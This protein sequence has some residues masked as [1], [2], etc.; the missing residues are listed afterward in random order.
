M[1]L[2]GTFSKVPEVTVLFWILKILTT[3]M[4]EVASDFLV[5]VLSPPTAIC[6]GAIGFIFAL[7]MQLKADRYR[8]WIYWLSIV[9][10]SVLGTMVADSM[11]VGLGIPYAFSTI[12]FII[13]LAALFAAWYSAE[14]TLSIHSI[15]TL[16]RELFYWGI[17]LATFALGTAA[18]DMTAATFHLGYLVSGIVFALLI[19]L[20][21]LARSV[22]KANGIATFWIAYILTRPLGASFAD[23]M[24][25]STIRGGLNIGTGQVTLILMLCIIGLVWYV[26]AT[27]EDVI[28][29][30]AMLK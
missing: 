29:R 17:V 23:W 16:K 4:G 8:P 11:H 19:T 30:K 25:V 18:G 27:H 21:L 14:R 5:R 13:I 22:F 2:P 28:T 15:Y 9:M 7:Y 24:G 10:V 3:G 12:G 26:T 6:L 20:P 1:L